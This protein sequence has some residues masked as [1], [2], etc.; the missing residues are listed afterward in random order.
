MKQQFSYPIGASTCGEL[1]SE[2]LFA[3]DI[4]AP[5]GTPIPNLGMW[6]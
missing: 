4:P 6:G 3:G 5:M 1:P 2:A